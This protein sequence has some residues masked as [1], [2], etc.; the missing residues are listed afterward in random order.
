M[1]I[2]KSVLTGCHPAGREEEFWFCYR[3]S[4]LVPTYGAGQGRKPLYFKVKPFTSLLKLKP[5]ADLRPLA[6][7]T[8]NVVW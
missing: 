2:D 6:A 3:S 7:L 1:G 8:G 4:A 5:T